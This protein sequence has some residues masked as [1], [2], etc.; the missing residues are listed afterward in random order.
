MSTVIAPAVPA[1]ARHRHARHVRRL[2]TYD[3]RDG[4]S[5]REIVSLPRSDGSVL[6]VDRLSETF[7]DARLVARLAPDE[8][9]ENA[10]IVAR[11]YLS[12]ETRGR[13]RLLSPEDW[14]ANGQTR[15][16][17]PDG[18]ATLQQEPLTDSAGRQYRLRIVASQDSPAEL[19]WTRSTQQNDDRFD[20]LKLRDVMAAIADYEPARTMTAAALSAHRDDQPVSTRRLAGEF[21]RITCSPIVL[22]RAL[23][24]AVEQKV[25]SSELTMSEIAVRCGRTKRDR[26]GNLS[27]ETSWLARRIGA[28]PEGG[29]AEPTQWVHIETLALIA[30]EGLGLNPNEVEL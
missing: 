22:N 6:V 15:L 19:C 7:T 26:R 21:E 11:M 16:D 24:E 2:G 17:S 20:V 29:E 14:D 23:R 10:L 30:R 8:P 13:C 5:G 27:G 3:G 9:S 18:L 4:G 25:L 12:D 1:T 28:L